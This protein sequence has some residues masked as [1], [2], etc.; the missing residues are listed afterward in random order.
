M[1]DDG[2]GAHD[3]HEWGLTGIILADEGDAVEA[4]GEESLQRLEFRDI[5][6]LVVPVAD[7]A[8]ELECSEILAHR[9][10]LER[11]MRDQA[12]LPARPGIVFSSRSTVMTFL[13]ERYLSIKE[14]FDAVSGRWE[15][16]LEMN[17]DDDILDDVGP[18]IY[19]ELR[20]R[21][22]LSMPFRRSDPH[23]YSA[24][25]LIERAATGLFRSRVAELAAENREITLEL[26]G[27]LPPYDFVTIQA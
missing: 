7:S 2:S 1:H 11:V 26:T 19:R 10:A 6:A 4:A 22:H 16:R 8:A 24:G 5:V 15:F 13:E 3:P 20:Q 18:A 12:V 25:F 23:V 17:A 14:A 27:P 9:R 21:A